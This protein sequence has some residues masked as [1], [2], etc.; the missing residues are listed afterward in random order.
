MIEFFTGAGCALFACGYFPQLRNWLG[1]KS[2]G[3]GEVEAFA[4]ATARSEQRL[5]SI[6]RILSVDHPNWRD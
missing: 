2:A 6:E 5:D 4:E 1:G 3:A